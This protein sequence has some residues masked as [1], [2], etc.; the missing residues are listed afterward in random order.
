MPEVPQLEL[1]LDLLESRAMGKHP[2]SFTT[3]FSKKKDLQYSHT[4]T[5]VSELHTRLNFAI[6]MLR[7]SVSMPS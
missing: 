1:N 5:F 3:H 6:P 4:V 2:G 7:I